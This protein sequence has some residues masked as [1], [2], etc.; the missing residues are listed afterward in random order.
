VRWHWDPRL[1]AQLA[2][3]SEHWQARLQAAARRLAVPTLLVSG[4]RSDLVSDATVD[5]FLALVPHAAHVRIDD[6][7]H[8]VAGDRND[9]FTD[10][11]L[12]FLSASTAARNGVAP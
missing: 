2:H 10:V 6:A 7:T 12:D 9:A 4:G 8:M 3:Q 1:L 5:E 11:I